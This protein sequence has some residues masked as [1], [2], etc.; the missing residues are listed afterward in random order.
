MGVLEYS[1]KFS[2]LSN[3]APS[4]VSNPRD[5]MSHFLTGVSKDL[6]EKSHLK[7]LHD[8]MNISCPVVHAQQM[9]ETKLRRQNREAN[10]VKPYDFMIQIGG[11]KI[12]DNLRFKNRFSINI[13]SIFSKASDDRVSNLMSL[14]GRGTSSPTKKRTYE[15]CD[16]KH[17]DCLVGMDNFFECGKSGYKVRNFPN[18]KGQDKGSVQVLASVSNVDAQ[19][20]NSFYALRSMGEQESSPCSPDVVTRM[21]QVFDIDLYALLYPSAT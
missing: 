12:Q 7:M 10:R 13:P 2:K 9:E 4:L 17:G 20:K 5:E 11:W 18:L 16:R 21:L 1:I 15:K 14:K 3:Y 8:N 6:V 19:K